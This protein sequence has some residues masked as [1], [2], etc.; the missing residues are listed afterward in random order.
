MLNIIGIKCKDQIFITQF[1]PT[2]SYT[3]YGILH[4]YVI[5]GEKPAPSFHE[6]WCVISGEIET[7][8]KYVSQPD[9]NHRYELIDSS[10]ESE[11]CKL[12]L[13]REEV[14]EYDKEEYRWVWKPEFTM[15]ESLYEMKW[16]THPD[17]LQDVEFEFNIIMEVEKVKEYEGFAYNVPRTQYKKDGLIPLTED[18]VTH[19]V[20][21]NTTNQSYEIIR[22]YVK[23]HINYDVAVITSDYDFCFTVKKKIPLSEQEKYTVD[24]NA[25]R[26]TKRKKLETRYRR[27]RELEVFA[28]APKLYQKYPVIGEFHGDNQED[29]KRNIDEYCESLVEFINTPVRDCPDCKGKGVIVE[30]FKKGKCV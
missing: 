12:V 11:K 13:P 20:I 8:Q 27:Y 24:L 18:H 25:F 4:N 6:Y 23:Q 5:N 9:T 2:S 30:K 26:N 28:M 14:V 15:Y 10:M 16:D 1:N 21:D 17:I 29:L 22:Q 3:P 7:V 19:Q